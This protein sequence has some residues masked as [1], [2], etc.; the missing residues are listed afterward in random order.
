VTKPDDQKSKEG[1]SIPVVVASRPV[2]SH[3]QSAVRVNQKHIEPNATDMLLKQPAV[4]NNIQQKES[5]LAS[6]Q[7]QFMSHG[8]SNLSVSPTGVVREAVSQTTP[9]SDSS[10]VG[11][12]NEIVKGMEDKKRLE[13]ELRVETEREAR[14]DELIENQTYFVHFSNATGSLKN[15]GVVLFV[16]LLVLLAIGYILVDLDII[17]LSI[18]LP[19]ELFK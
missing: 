12:V 16:G 15:I 17:P 2:V 18:K 7:K 9:Q 8:S 6:A 11:E 4:S 14:V 19:F 1:I 5:Q 3:A 13:E 10:S